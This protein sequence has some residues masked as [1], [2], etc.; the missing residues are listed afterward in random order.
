MSRE[1]QAGKGQ[2][3]FQ[4]ASKRVEESRELPLVS[5]QQELREEPHSIC[6]RTPVP[7]HYKQ[8]TSRKFCRVSTIGK[9]SQ[10]QAGIPHQ[11]ASELLP[12]DPTL[13]HAAPALEVELFLW[14]VTAECGSLVSRVSVSVW[15]RIETRYKPPFLQEG[16]KERALLQPAVP[17]QEQNV[18]FTD[19]TPDTP[20]C[21]RGM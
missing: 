6:R 16:R 2:D 8:N 3:G 7:L 17:Q 5:K 20:E 14:R 15:C 4:E 9:V 1:V 12:G 19:V 10:N 11:K 21:F 18:H 13:L